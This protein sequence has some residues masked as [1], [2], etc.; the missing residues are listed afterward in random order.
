MGKVIEALKDFPE[1][2]RGNKKI[3]DFLIRAGKS[4]RNATARKAE[5]L[6]KKISTVNITSGINQ[7]NL[8]NTVIWI[9]SGS[10]TSLLQF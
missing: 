1:T 2:I 7:E 3:T 5:Q 4:T 10:I 8:Q 9:P 6:L